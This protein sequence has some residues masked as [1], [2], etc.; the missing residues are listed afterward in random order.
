MEQ[1]E[2]ERVEVLEEGHRDP[3]DVP[4]TF[5]GT[6]E[7]DDAMDVD[8]VPDS[9]DSSSE[10]D[11]DSED[12]RTPTLVAKTASG[13]VSGSQ[14]TNLVVNGP[15]GTPLFNASVESRIS[16]K[17]KRKNKRKDDDALKRKRKKSAREKISTDIR[18]KGL[19][20]MRS[21]AIAA[22][23]QFGGHTLSATAERT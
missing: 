19:A 3:F 9:I 10:S 5:L 17:R 20:F 18:K 1:G 13:R 22:A 6:A 21:K 7:H 23:Q 2:E 15:D 16:Q 12:E 8:Q 11:S 4:D 14:M